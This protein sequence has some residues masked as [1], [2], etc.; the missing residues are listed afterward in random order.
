LLSFSSLLE[1]TKR[2]CFGAFF[3]IYSDGDEKTDQRHQRYLKYCTKLRS[4]LRECRIIVEI[5]D[6]SYFASIYDP[7]IIVEIEDMSY[8]ASIYDPTFGQ[9]YYDFRRILRK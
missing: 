8:F 9:F 5:E 3:V 4:F 6:M 2:G 1:T 7:S